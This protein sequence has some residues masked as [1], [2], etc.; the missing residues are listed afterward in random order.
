VSR[1]SNSEVA[2]EWSV[3]PEV[4]HLRIE[5]AY[6]EHILQN[7]TD[8]ALKATERGRIRIRATLEELDRRVRVTVSDTGRGIE[9][10]RVAQLFELFQGTNGPLGSRAAY[11][12]GLFLVRKF[13]ERL[14]AKIDVATQ[15]GEGTSFSVLLP[16]EPKLEEEPQ[17]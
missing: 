4:P 12:C 16:I 8:N 2:L 11:G 9:P 13:C 14:G 17:E 15:V 1:L 10:H 6:L 7:L 5:K 3:D